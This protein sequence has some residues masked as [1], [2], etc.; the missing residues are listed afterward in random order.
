V[1]KTTSE[2]TARSVQGGE[3]RKR[4]LHRPSDATRDASRNARCAVTPVV[5]SAAPSGAIL[6]GAAAVNAFLDSRARRQPLPVNGIPELDGLQFL[7]ANDLCKL[8]RISKPTLWRLRRRKGFPKPTEVS[9]RLV[10]WRRSEIELWLRARQSHGPSE[11]LQEPPR[12]SSDPAVA[13]HKAVSVARR[14]KRPKPATQDEHSQLE[15]PFQ[16]TRPL[17][18]T[19]R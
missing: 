4:Q 16:N 15:L 19:S 14:A 5:S 1:T 6:A 10:A 12:L 2:W 13:D 18:R 9:E 17:S 8:L 7:R 3:L 11:H